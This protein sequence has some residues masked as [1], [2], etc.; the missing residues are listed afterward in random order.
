M[1]IS[2][3]NSRHQLI[4]NIIFDEL[5]KSKKDFY[6]TDIIVK[7]NKHNDMKYIVSDNVIIIKI[8]NEFKTDGVLEMIQDFYRPKYM[9]E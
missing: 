6:F 2:F 5:I 9:G 3:K 4:K 8:L 1:A 7:I